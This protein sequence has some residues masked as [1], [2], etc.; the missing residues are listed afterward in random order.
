MSNITKQPKAWTDNIPF[1]PRDGHLLPYAPFGAESNSEPIYRDTKDC[2]WKDNYQF[3]ALIKITGYGRGRSSA[4]FYAQAQQYTAPQYS[5][6]QYQFFMSEMERIISN[7][8]ITKGLIHYGHLL[9]FDFKVNCP[10]YTFCKKGGSYSLQ[11][12]LTP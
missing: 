1:N 5:A 3:Q 4:V 8:S 10:T 7:C 6:P 12:V 11:L 2:V 9:C